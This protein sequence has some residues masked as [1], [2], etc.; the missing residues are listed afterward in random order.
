MKDNNTC[1]QQALLVCEALLHTAQDFNGSTCRSAGI[2]QP[3][4]YLVIAKEHTGA[5]ILVQRDTLKL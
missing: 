4:A 2:A 5:V 3:A 1:K